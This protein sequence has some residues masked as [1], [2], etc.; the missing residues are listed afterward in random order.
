MKIKNHEINPALLIVDMQNG[1]VSK[2][3]SYD[4]M[5]LNVS[6]YCEVVPYL[7]RLVAFCRR[8]KIP[9]FYSQAVRE[10]SGIDL[11]TRSHRIL[12][13]SREER[14]KKRPI[15]IR[16]SWDAEIVD[17]LMPS[18]DDHV[19]IKRRDSVFQDT[20]VEVWLRSLGIDSIIFSGIDT[21]ICVESS[22]RDA[23]NHGYDV[24]LISD[25]TASNNLDHYN[26]TLDNIRNYYGLVMNLDEF[27]SNS[28]NGKDQR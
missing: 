28:N 4:L 17:E 1:F 22:L 21:S 7:K 24:V 27:T 14:I 9:I 12:P 8:V 10:E 11:L 26:S 25:A 19:V 18:L 20:E 2:G 23:F 13:K 16:G 5:G 3:G 15:C 6:R